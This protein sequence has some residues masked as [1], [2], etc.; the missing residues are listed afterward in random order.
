MRWVKL[1]AFVSLWTCSFVCVALVHL[2]ISVLR[3]P[4]RWVIISRL[5]RSIAFLMRTILNIRVTV[6][7]DAG[8][9]ERRLLIISNHVSY[10]DGFVLGS[11]FPVV[12]V[13]GPGSQ[14]MAS[15]R[16]V[17]D[18][19]GHDF[20]QPPEEGP[21]VVAGFGNEQKTKRKNEC[22]VVS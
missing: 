9:F 2:W 18:L 1:V 15:D 14:E 7:G 4:N 5:K 11:I 12:F 21:G 8:Q 19:I 22:P 13:Y 3:L 6:V 17:D 10:I 20:R 16:S